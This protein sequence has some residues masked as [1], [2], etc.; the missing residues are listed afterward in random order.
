VNSGILDCLSQCTY[1]AITPEEAWI[2]TDEA[3]ALPYPE[4]L[5]TCHMVVAP[6]RHVSSLYALDVGEQR[7]LWA[8]VTEIRARLTR[9]MR[10]E[11]FYLGF[12]DFPEGDAAH[13]LVHVVPRVSGEV[14][15]LPDGIE[16]VDPG[17]SIM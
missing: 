10:V 2:A 6:R 1:C 16:W 3:I 11:G 8:L 4:P 5:A 13:A 17:Q 9:S 12:A 14:V 15:V 7:A